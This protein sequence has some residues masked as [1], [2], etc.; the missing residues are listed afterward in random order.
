VVRELS[1]VDKKQGETPPEWPDQQPPAEK[2]PAEA[3]MNRFAWDLRY[4]GPHRLPGEV[5][6]EFRSRGPIAPPGI[7]QVRLNAEG[8]SLTV[9]LELKMDPRVNVSLADMQKEFDLELK[10]RGVLS[11]LHDTVNEIRE[12]RVQIRGLRGR[13]E[14]A[15]YKSI[16][17]S[18]N[19]LEKKMTPVEDQL[20]QTNAKSSEAN[21]NYPVLIDEQLHSLVFSV[22][23]DG[24]PTQQQYAAFESLSQ[25]AAPLFAQWR[26]IKSSDLVALNDMMKQ[27]SVPLIYLASPASEA[28][29][30]QAAGENQKH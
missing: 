16:D 4:D 25:Q 24:A 9:P 7:Y 1:S 12:T 30:T 29:S 10:I 20:L 21:L 15:R 27:E 13:L 2:I 19:A 5:Q 28:K 23:Y 18:A 22:E 14:D 17:E 6:A 8:K 26:S 11:D 3:G